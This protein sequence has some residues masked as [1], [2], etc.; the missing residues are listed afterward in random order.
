MNDFFQITLESGKCAIIRASDVQNAVEVSDTLVNFK[1]LEG[2][3]VEVE[4]VKTLEFGVIFNEQCAD[5][6]ALL[7]LLRGERSQ[8][9]ALT[10]EETITGGGS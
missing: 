7:G 8:V 6:I 1:M 5:L 3:E 2:K 9:P 10:P 4:G